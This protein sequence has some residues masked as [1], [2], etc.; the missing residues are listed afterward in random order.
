MESPGCRGALASGSRADGAARRESES[1]SHIGH[2]ARHCPGA[3]SGADIDRHADQLLGC[4]C[5]QFGRDRAAGC[6][7]HCRPGRGRETRAGLAGLPEC[8]LR[9][10]SAIGRSRRFTATGPTPP[11]SR[12]SRTDTQMHRFVSVDEQGDQPSDTASWPASRLADSLRRQGRPGGDAVHRT[13][14][15]RP[16]FGGSRW[17]SRSAPRS[18]PANRTSPDYFRTGVSTFGPRSGR[19][20]IASDAT[21]MT[22]L[23]GVLAYAEPPPCRLARQF[24]GLFWAFIGTMVLL[25]AIL[26]AVI[27]YVTLAVNIVERTNELATLRAAGVPIRRVAGTIAT[28]NLA[29]TTLG[30]PIG[31]AA[32]CWL[33]G[34]P[35]VVQ[36]RPV[37]L[38]PRPSAG[39][40]SQ[41]RSVAVWRPRLVTVARRPRRTP[42]RHRPRRT[43][44]VSR[45]R[46]QMRSSRSRQRL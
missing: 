17:T 43:R 33:P 34:V 41:P 7:G 5:R 44:S 16:S 10:R 2:D 45:R 30:L 32:A 12:G 37:H 23:P 22:A 28:E 18:T 25:G 6:H 19:G 40:R 46:R 3:D 29:A 13:A 1:A 38:P 20:W 15:T 35:R 24:L 11:C 42:P 8:R 36:Q 31:V 27:I 21:P 14:S 4:D 39:G 26:A 9:S